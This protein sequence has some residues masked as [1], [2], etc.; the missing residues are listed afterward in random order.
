MAVPEVV[1]EVEFA[2]QPIG[3]HVHVS[4][5]MLIQFGPQMSLPQIAFECNGTK[6]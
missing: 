2:L 6:Y 1:P 5:S 3:K 4:G